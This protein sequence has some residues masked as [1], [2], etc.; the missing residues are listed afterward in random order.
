MPW[1]RGLG[2]GRASINRGSPS[3]LGVGDGCDKPISKMSGL[4][5]GSSSVA[6]SPANCCVAPRAALAVMERLEGRRAVEDPPYVS[7]HLLNGSC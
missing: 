6:A 4:R 7:V 5:K 3:H 1:R 2:V